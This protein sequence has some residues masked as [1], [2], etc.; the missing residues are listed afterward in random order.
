MKKHAHALGIIRA[1]CIAYLE[2]ERGQ[3]L[4]PNYT[5]HELDSWRMGVASRIGL[6]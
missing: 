4:H 1:M 3:P 2:G 5:Q 6:K